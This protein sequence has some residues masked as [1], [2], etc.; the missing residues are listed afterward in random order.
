M[1]GS[2]SPAIFKNFRHLRICDNIYIGHGHKY[3]STNFAPLTLP[4]IP[5]EYGDEIV[6]D[7][8]PTVEEENAIAMQLKG[9]N[10]ELELIDDEGDDES[11]ENQ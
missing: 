5:A 7:D 3:S 2:Q 4:R 10:D 11:D 1:D 9:S 8:D 6:D